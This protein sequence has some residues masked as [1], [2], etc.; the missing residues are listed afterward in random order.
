M[1][2]RMKIRG[3]IVEDFVNYKKPS[4]YIAFPEC[5]F[6]CGKA[7]CQNYKLYES[8]IINMEIDTIIDIY[9]NNPITSAVVLSGLDPI[10]TWEETK[11]FI[12]NF[13]QKSDDDIVIYTGYNKEEIQNKISFLSHFPN[14][15][16]KYGR[17]F[18]GQKSHYDEV[19]GVYLSSNNQYAEVLK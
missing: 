4:M 16:I 13:R 3:L 6:K 14:I 8:K 12:I 17:Y 9:L 10:D 18:P 7:L 11:D 15:I 1:V 5:T 2:K 19:L